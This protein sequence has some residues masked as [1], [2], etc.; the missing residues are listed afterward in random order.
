MKSNWRRKESGRHLP[1]YS[2]TSLYLGIFIIG[3]FYVSLANANIQPID[4]EPVVKKEQ[5]DFE[6]DTAPLKDGAES[7]VPA[8]KRAMPTSGDGSVDMDVSFMHAFIASLSIIIVSE[9]GD[10][11]FFISAIMAMSHPRLTVFAGAMTALAGM[12]VLSALFGYVITIIPRIYVFY[13]STA[14]FA[15]FGVKMLREGWGMSEDEAKE[16]LE[17]VQSEI[18]KRDDSYEREPL[19][20]G[21]AG[22]LRRGSRM[23]VCLSRVFIQSF[24]LNLLAEWGDRSQIAT[25]IMAARE[26]ISGVIV[27]GLIGH[28]L[29][30]GL[31]VMGGRIV[32]AW[33]SVRTGEWQL[34]WGLNSLSNPMHSCT[35]SLEAEVMM[36]SLVVLATPIKSS[37]IY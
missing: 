34:V 31:A 28:F 25:V 23:L 18:R 17:E 33:I 27:G 14:L 6:D 29:C 2:H 3:V 37:N 15:I 30:T 21:G 36:H 13:V 22:T 1:S 19:E 5:P 35:L 9:L 7:G 11:T 10:K 20:E 16:E 32:A 8:I 12:H 24:T 26:D 4:V